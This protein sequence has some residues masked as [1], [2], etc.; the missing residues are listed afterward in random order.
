MC[1]FVAI[2]PQK[3]PKQ[4]N[5]PQKKQKNSF[6]RKCHFWAM[7]RA[8]APLRP[9]K[10]SGNSRGKGCGAGKVSGNFRGTFGEKGALRGA[11]RQEPWVLK[12]FKMGFLV[13]KCEIFVPW[14]VLS[15]S[16]RKIT[17]IVSICLKLSQIVSCSLQHSLLDCWTWLLA[18]MH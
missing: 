12:F 11:L 10:L 2:W 17:K 15:R 14:C 13:R 1:L 6:G 18:L 7:L 16:W 3:R 8:H 5:H 4:G 9:Q